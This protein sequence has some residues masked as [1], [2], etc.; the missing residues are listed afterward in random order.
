MTGTDE[1]EYAGVPLP[2]VWIASDRLLSAE[3]T[4]RVLNALATEK[5]IAEH[6]RRIDIKGENLPAK[7]GSGPHRGIDNNHSERRTIHYGS[8]EVVLSKLVG[9]FYIELKVIDEDEMNAVVE[10]IK[11]VCSSVMPFGYTMNVGRYSKYR[12]TLSDIN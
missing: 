8:E 9:D 7:I 4:E 1:S 3:S 12:S 11:E 6:T 5:F 2:Q 10:K